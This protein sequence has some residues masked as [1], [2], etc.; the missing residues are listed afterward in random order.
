M[1]AAKKLAI[2]L[3][4]SSV[5]K[6]ACAMM[7]FNVPMHVVPTYPASVLRYAAQ[8]GSV[9][10]RVLAQTIEIASAHVFATPTPMYAWTPVP[11]VAASVTRFAMKRVTV[12]NVRVVPM[13]GRV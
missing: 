6:G 3:V 5:F 13:M 4:M 11:P 8:M 12:V 2:A 9:K 7:T 10:S 1:V